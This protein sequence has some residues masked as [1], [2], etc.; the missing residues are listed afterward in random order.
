MPPA[1]RF[2]KCELRGVLRRYN[3]SG[4]ERT[5]TPPLARVAQTFLDVLFPPRCVACG[6]QG[7]FLCPG[8]RGGDAARPAAALPAVLAARAAG[9]ECGRCAQ[10]RP[11]FAGVRSLYLFQ[12]PVREA[13]HALKY[14]H[15]SALA[16]PMG[17]PM[18]AYLKAEALPVDLVV[19]VPLFG[20]RQRVRGY[21]QS[22]LLAQ[23]GGAAGRPSPGRAWPV[24]PPRYAASGPQRRRRGPPPQRR[25]RLRRRRTSGGGTARPPRRRRDDHRRHAG[26]LRPGAAPGRRGLCL[27]A[28]LRTRRRDG[29]DP[30]LGAARLEGVAGFRLQY[31]SAKTRYLKGTGKG[32][33]RMELTFRA[34]HV[35]VTDRPAGVHQSQA[36]PSGP[37]SPAGG[38]G[39]GRA[40]AGGR[41]ERPPLRGPAHCELQ[42]HLSAGRRA[43]PTI[44]GR[45]RRRR[46]R[47]V[48]AGAALQGEVV[49]QRTSGRGQGGGSR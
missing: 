48:A 16:R 10:T 4:M 39:G 41:R 27:G 6:E 33:D 46:R 42:W 25:R 26:R 38:R 24:P 45:Y 34:R 23:R 22:A 43:R 1:I 47:P 49:P 19:P 15:L 36:E 2:Q 29:D 5:K 18:A 28:D 9:R 8:L 30:A 21:N 32:K 3:A 12:G 7:A 11:A 31:N 44:A 40:G 17:A 35:P 13:V 37:L 14:N 20:R